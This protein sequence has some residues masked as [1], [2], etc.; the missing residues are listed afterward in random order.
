MIS[1]VPFGVIQQYKFIWEN[2]NVACRVSD[3]HQRIF[4]YDSSHNFSACSASFIH[5][6]MHFCLISCPKA[7]STT[8]LHMD[9]AYLL[10][11]IR[12][13]DGQ[14]QFKIKASHSIYSPSSL[15][16]YSL[17]SAPLLICLFIEGVCYI[18][19]ICG[20]NPCII[21]LDAIMV[22]FVWCIAIVS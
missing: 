3:G 16:L 17:L 9:G 1:L 11:I 12:I 6:R 4:A 8:S 14:T 22:H 2:V 18:S 20:Q 7:S 15:S 10:M 5:I 19:H 13:L 21:T